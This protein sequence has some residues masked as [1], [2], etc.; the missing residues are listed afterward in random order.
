MKRP[1][2]IL[3]TDPNYTD[4]RIL[5]VT[6]ACVAALPPQS[7]AVQLRDKKRDRAA[8]RA[9]AEKL[10]E[11]TKPAGV[12][13]ALLLVNGDAELARLV[14]ADGV[15]LGGNAM[16]VVDARAIFG[17]GAFV[18]IAAHSDHA[19]KLGVKDG[20]DGALVS[21]IFASPEK[22]AGRGTLALRSARAVAGPE[23]AIYALGGVD[24]ENA[25]DCVMAG[26]DGIAAIRALLL[27][28]D[29]GADV[30]AIYDSMPRNLSEPHADLR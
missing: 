26:A 23:F 19:V 28:R 16:S 4:E 21:S 17:E 15:H 30:R 18:T 24:R 12:A 27:A 8:V 5:E 20:A 10:R 3:V 6:R 13:T 1:K 22:T 11:A 25:A 2:I 9:F 7:F 29:P 14:G